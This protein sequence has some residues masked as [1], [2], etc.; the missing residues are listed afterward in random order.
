M[1]VLLIVVGYRILQICHGLL[2]DLMCETHV[3]HDKES[4]LRL[5]EEQSPDLVFLEDQLPGSDVN[6]VLA[7]MQAQPEPRRIPILL[8]RAGSQDI[9]LL[10]TAAEVMA[11]WFNW[12]RLAM[13][14]RPYVDSDIVARIDEYLE[15][16]T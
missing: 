9:P 5:I 3:A 7:W 4:A 15:Q 11:E 1:R 6:D 14:M 12:R 13:A 10:D 16:G 8:L 2:D